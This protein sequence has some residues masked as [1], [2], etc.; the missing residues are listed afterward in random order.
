[1]TMKKQRVKMG[2][3]KDKWEKDNSLFNELKERGYIFGRDGSVYSTFSS[4]FLKPSLDTY[5]YYKIAVKF[6]GKMVSL[7][8]HRLVAMQYIPNPDCKPFINHID[9]NKTNNNVENLEWC[10][11]SENMR[12]AVINNIRNTPRGDSHHLMK[13]THCNNGHKYIEGVVV[14]NRGRPARRCRVCNKDGAKRYRDRLKLTKKSRASK[15]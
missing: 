12:H 8:V 2:D 13:R 15:G 7:R 3:T 14:N 6:G 1:V 11:P 5:G 10:T 9:C 4:R